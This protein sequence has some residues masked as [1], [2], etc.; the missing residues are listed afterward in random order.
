MIVSNESETA[1][2]LKILRVTL[3][4]IA[5]AVVA[6]CGGSEQG[7]NDQPSPAGTVSAET[8]VAVVES[9]DPAEEDAVAGLNEVVH[10]GGDVVPALAP[11]L[12]DDDPNRRWAA[13][14]LIALLTDSEDEVAVL[15]PVLEDDELIF[16][17]MAAGSLAGLGV[18]DSL[19]VLIEGLS[20]DAELP[21]SD[22]PRPLSAYARSTLEHYTGESFANAADWEDWWDEISSDIRWDGEGYVAS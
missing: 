7:T 9:F 20:S 13:L 1:S 11:L 12:K 5:G 22:P 21:F 19:P 18:V 3:L 17:V 6:A 15:T 4:A 2:M 16:G 8:A 14:Y 10:A